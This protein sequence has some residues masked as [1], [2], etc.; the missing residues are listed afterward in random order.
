MIYVLLAGKIAFN[1]YFKS[2]FPQPEWGDLTV[3]CKRQ[4]GDAAVAVIRDFKYPRLA[5]RDHGDELERESNG[6]A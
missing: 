6:K 2:T 1:E 3:K 4:W 5:I